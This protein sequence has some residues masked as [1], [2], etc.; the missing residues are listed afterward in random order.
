MDKTFDDLRVMLKANYPLLYFATSE[1]ERVKQ[2][3][4]RIAFE[5][6]Y[7]FNSWDIVEGLQSHGKNKN[8]RVEKIEKHKLHG[9]TKNADAFLGELKALIEAELK[10][11]GESN[12]PPIKEVYFIEDFHKYFRDE[13]VLVY[14]RKLTTL[15]K[16]TNK[17]LILVSPFLKLPDE[18]EKYVTIVNVPLP[19]R[20][21]LKIR[22]NAVKDKD[23]VNPDLEKYLID[24]ALG[25]T[26]MEADLAFRL[27]KEK[28]GLNSKEATRIISNEKEQ[29]IKKSGILDYYQVDS[30]LEKNVGGLSNLKSWLKQRSKAFELKAKNFGLK[31]PKGILLLGVPGCGKSLTAK[32]VATEWK[33][34]LLRL[35]IG[36]V[37]QAEVGSSENNIRLAL[38]TAEAVAPCV[39]WIDEIEKGLNVGGGEKDGGTNSRV[40]STIL[41]WMQEKTKPVFVIA[42]ANNISDLP[43]ELLR[44]GRFDEIFFIDLPTKE[45]RKNILQIHLNKH[46]Q[47]NI[48]DLDTLADQSKYFNGAEIE[49]T[50]KEAMFLSY[51]EDAD[52]SQISMRH[53]E[54]ATKQIVPLAQTMKRKIDGLREWATT[55]ARPASAERNIE[56]LEVDEKETE[57]KVVQTKREKQEDIF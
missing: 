13:R 20:D 44:K 10:E 24:S 53:L 11:E 52:N 40:F 34:P 56:K 31:E 15:L 1:Y 54:Q 22:L 45:E 30:E 35:D 50:V 49:E 57:T 46:G 38:A 17:H 47:K 27:A 16:G 5:M 18:L 42:T 51:V 4:R 28:V 55:R 19:D 26:D 39:L 25:M 2:K 6:D 7:T 9:S 37:F 48:T 8:N 33:Q 32:C 21:D 3:A 23:D 41:T 29:I 12:K 14:L 43:P 36:K